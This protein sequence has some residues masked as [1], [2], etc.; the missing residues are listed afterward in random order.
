[1][2]PDIDIEVHR[3]IESGTMMKDYADLSQAKEVAAWLN[4]R[5]SGYGSIADDTQ[6]VRGHADRDRRAKKQRTA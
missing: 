2:Q 1:L 6:Q 5:Q 3:L 4:S